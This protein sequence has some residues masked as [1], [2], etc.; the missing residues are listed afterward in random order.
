MGKI[1]NGV[2]LTS[3]SVSKHH[4]DS[5]RKTR[6]N[7]R[8]ETVS[9]LLDEHISKTAIG[10]NF[11]AVKDPRPEKACTSSVLSY[12]ILF[13][14]IIT[15]GVALY[16]VVVSYSSLP[17]WDGWMEVQAAAR[18]RSLLSPAWLW[19]RDNK[20][21]VVVPK[22]FLAADLRLFQ[23][24]Q[25]FLLA[26]IFCIQLLHLALLSWSMRALGGWRGALW[27][28]GTGL[29]AFCLFC[30]TQW[31]N[32]VIGF[33]VCFVLPQ[34]LGTVSFVAVLLYWTKSQQYPEKRW[35]RSPCNID[36]GRGGSKLFPGQWNAPVADTHN[37]GI[38]PPLA[39]HS[40]PELC[41]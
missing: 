6:P 30:P 15:I 37:R 23:G 22:L 27:R 13:G 40:Y 12:V 33:Q 11:S 9:Y 32:F 20:H 38:L 5:C 31:G 14:G 18:D 29:A 3:L 10:Y 28:T 34:L 2:L 24:R 7:E 25:I 4:N 16:M 17:F 26:S 19:E 41:H 1:H 21:R 39:P 8:N 36:S 35:L